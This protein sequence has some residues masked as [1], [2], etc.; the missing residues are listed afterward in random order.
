MNWLQ[1]AYLIIS[2]QVVQ[3]FLFATALVLQLSASKY[4]A[5]AWKANVLSGFGF[6]FMS[7]TA[8]LVQRYVPG[9]QAWYTWA[10]G[11]TFAL[12]ASFLLWV[13]F[14]RRR[15]LNAQQNNDAQPKA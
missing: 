7:A 3:L 8:F 13:G 4:K 11:C 5:S 1:F 10:A 14:T 15:L 2:L 9:D 12:F 6:I